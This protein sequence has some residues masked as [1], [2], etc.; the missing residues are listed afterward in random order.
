MEE[1]LEIINNIVKGCRKH[2]SRSQ[3]E[4]Y[5]VFY[6]FSLSICQRYAN[7][8][9]DASCILN[10]GF[11]K[12]FNQ[13]DSFNVEKPIAPWIRKIMINTSID[14]CRKKSKFENNVEIEDYVNVVKTDDFVYS[15]LR[16]EEL[17]KLIQKLSPMYRTVFNLYAIEGFNHNEISKQL[18]ISVGT[19]K[20]NLSK[21]RTKLMEMVKTLE[22]NSRYN[23]KES[24]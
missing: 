22:D 20:S 21:A 12:I 7:N 8:R 9:D 18:N 2:D 16:Y 4:L 23:Y 6:D 13:I 17:L 19:S 15:K 14:Y 5:R 11:Y 24:Y 10:E 3:K 1:R